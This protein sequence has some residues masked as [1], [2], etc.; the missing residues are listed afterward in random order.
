MMRDNTVLFVDDEPLVLSSLKRE[1]R[2]EEFR[3]IFVSNGVEALELL[4][5]EKVNVIVTDMRMPKMN[6]LE[7]LKIVKEKYPDVTRIVLSGY[8]QLP[9]IIATINN[10]D[11]YKFIPKPWKFDEEFKPAIDEAIEF[12]N[13][14]L[15]QK[16]LIDELSQRKQLLSK[17]TDDNKIETTK[18]KQEL[19]KIK[20]INI[21]SLNLIQAINMEE[22]KN[23]M[24]DN[25]LE[26]FNSYLDLLPLNEAF[27]NVVNLEKNLQ[28]Y[29]G[30]K[31]KEE[32]II[33]TIGSLQC[34][35]KTY[36]ELELWILRQI[37]NIL[38]EH[39]KEENRVLAIKLGDNNGN[40]QV[41]II[42]KTNI[43]NGQYCSSSNYQRN[44]VLIETQLNL[45][46]EFLQGSRDRIEY[47]INNDDIYVE[48]I[49][50]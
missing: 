5:R 38:M 12:N 13:I 41:R 48:F 24:M 2:K 32:L 11:I 26:Y 45:L 36:F 34:D 10:G 35:F 21:N 1:L 15:N 23:Q 7:L 3:S 16:E 18:L 46:K 49:I 29:V 28:E 47:R 31:Y 22:I 17:D 4:E 8:T 9:Q 39:S 30:H 33:R 14:K 43:A 44:R 25:Y 42:T 6:G 50:N 37:V 20:D 40:P 19:K 27:F